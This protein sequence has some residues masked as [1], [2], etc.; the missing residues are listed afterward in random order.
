MA[1][2]VIR[3]KLSEPRRPLCLIKTKEGISM[4]KLGIRQAI[5]AA[6]NI[7]VVA[8]LAGIV[9]AQQQVTI[10][11]AQGQ[12]SQQMEKDKADCT[13][14]A[15][16]SVAQQPAAAPQGAKG[17]RARGAARGAAV[18]AVHAENQ[19]DQYG[20]APQ[21][22][23]DEYR[24]QQAQQAAKAGAVAG[25]SAQRRSNRQQAQQ[26]QTSQST[27]M[28]SAFRSCMTGRGYTVK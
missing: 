7:A 2:L 22:V 14:I 10:S 20:R 9:Q 1:R 23:Q 12:S 21:G 3:L 19:A 16:Q 4:G 17:G 8:G 11:P 18:G 6:A 27:A 26:Q 13:T 28:D 24:Q 15:Q 5:R 25:A